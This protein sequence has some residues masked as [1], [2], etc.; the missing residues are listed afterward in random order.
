MSAHFGV[1]NEQQLVLP[2]SIYLIGYVLGPLL[3]GPLSESY[4]RQVIM[5]VT[6]AGYTVFTLGACVAPN[7]AAFIIFRLLTGIFAASPISVTGG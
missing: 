2:N 4:G 3:F 6:F 5:L 1:S 7:Y